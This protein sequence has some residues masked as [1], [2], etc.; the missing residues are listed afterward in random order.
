MRHWKTQTKLLVLAGLV[1]GIF[2][3]GV[4]FLQKSWEKQMAFQWEEENKERASF[5]SRTMDILGRQLHAFA[6]DYSYWDEMIAFVRTGDTAWARENIA[7]SFETYQADVAWAFK[8]DGRLTYAMTLPGAEA[9]LQDHQ[10]EDNLRRTLVGN[11]FGHYFTATILG[12]LEVWIAPVQPTADNKRATPAQG[13]FVVGKLWTEELL[14]MLGATV[15]VDIRIVNP[16]AEDADAHAVEEDR[17]KGILHFTHPLNGPDGRPEAILVCREPM[18]LFAVLKATGHN[19][20]IYMGAFIL[21]IIIV[22]TFSLHR[23]VSLPLKYVM[24]GLRSGDQ[25]MFDRLANA[26][27]EFERIGEL[28]AEFMAQKADLEAE[29]ADRKRS[30]DE[31]RASETRF[32][33]VAEQVGQMIYDWD[34]TSG[35]IVWA[36][37]I[38]SITG[39]TPDEYRQVDINEWERMIHPDDRQAASDALAVAAKA[40][41]QYAVEYRL[42]KKDGSY[43]FVEDNGI[44]LADESGNSTRMLGTMKDISERKQAEASLRDRERLLKATLESTV[45]G[46]MVAEGN[47]TPTHWNARFVELW[48]IPEEVLVAGDLKMLSA[49]FLSQMKS[50]EGY[51]AHFSSLFD[52]PNESNTVIEL[53]DG[54]SFDVYSWPLVKDGLVSGRVWSVRDIT[55]RLKDE[56]ARRQLQE[57]LDRAERYESLGLLAG[58]VAHDLNNMLGPIGGYA[59]M[60]ARELPPESKIAARINKIIKSSEDAAAVIQD[61][62][63]LARR[64][65]YEFRT[66]D[67]NG[68]VDRYL[69]SAAFEKIRERFPAVELR[70]ELYPDGGFIVGSESHLLKVIMN[71]IV[72]ALEAMPPEGGVVTVR[73]EIARLGRLFSGFGP[74]PEGEYAILRIK[75]T[76]SGIAEEDL[77]KIFEPYFSKKHLGQSGSGLGLAVVYGI[78]KDH[79]GYYDVFSELGQGTEFVLYFPLSEAAVCPGET[80]API[81]QTGNETVLVVDDSAEQRELVRDIAAGLGYT[82]HAVENGHQAAEFVARQ[83]VDILV[84]D[85]I[86]EPGFDGLDTYREIVKIR[87]GQKAIV[88]SGYSETERVREMM[89]LGSGSFLKKPYRVDDLAKAIRKELDRKQPVA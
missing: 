40:V 78:I 60:I 86:M 4:W 76:G 58:G 35:A 36:G 21:G 44:F 53:S 3:S 73:T 50:P 62:L 65:R 79:H 83:P 75:D 68:V 34:C 71:L 32:R 14:A 42:R 64:G 77:A 7:S 20:M 19:R 24:E 8:P 6:Y 39:F 27:F 25:A 1:I 49:H 45:D 57:K 28:A 2:L 38:E 31:L 13:Y 84:L 46:I 29:I 66:I 9:L 67:L 5:L 54:R 30:E 41:G 82:V 69:E 16:G 85:M 56:E 55:P 43:T 11:S 89:R 63:T 18:E 22:L 88:V 37:A 23:W 33:L 51:Q 12:L 47:G 81:G 80:T 59:E 52:S 26:G 74:V 72:N 70:R 48:R 10:L 17:R 15:M 61:L 87:P